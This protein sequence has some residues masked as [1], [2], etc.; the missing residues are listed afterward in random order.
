MSEP[1]H[2]F[3]RALSAAR[4]A[5][6]SAHDVQRLRAQLQAKLLHEPAA[7][8]TPK[9]AAPHAASV[10]FTKLALVGAG[11]CIAG[12]LYVGLQRSAAPPRLQAR[13]PSSP[14]SAPDQPPA[15]SSPASAPDQPPALSSPTARRAP[16]ERPPSLGG[17]RDDT[18]LSAQPMP[19]RAPTQSAPTPD[20]PKQRGHARDRAA[21]ATINQ[22]S[23]PNAAARADSA[24]EI[25]LI[26]RAQGL[27]DRQ[28]T[29]ALT[30]LLEHER[31]FPRGILA[32]ER[33]A[34]RVEAE[35]A[36][37]R[38]SQAIAH[39][40]AFCAQYPNSPQTRTLERW[41][42]A[43]INADAEHK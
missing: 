35:R 10:S 4:D 25:A 6:G 9:A 8:T 11:L 28:P 22:A 12:A 41:L 34:L 14:A 37:G 42:A 33:D 15:L 24:A 26:E 1:T 43:R 27:L 5:T 20:K 29:A 38:T 39:A 36:L 16:A 19:M 17:A 31:Q 7:A 18:Q 3:E 23:Q 21:P 32:E 30:A 2:A 13:E 40:R